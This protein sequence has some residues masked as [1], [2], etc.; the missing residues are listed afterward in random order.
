MFFIFMKSFIL[1]RIH[2][3]KRGSARIVAV[4]LDNSNLFVFQIVIGLYTIINKFFA[5]FVPL[6]LVGARSNVVDSGE[7]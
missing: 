6:L 5:I 3:K 2:S 4:I 7:S 1:G